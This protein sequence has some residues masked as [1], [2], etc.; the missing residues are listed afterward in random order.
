MFAA[1]RGFNMNTPLAEGAGEGIT[2]PTELPVRVLVNALHARSGGGIT[3]LRNMLPHLAADQA[4]DLHLC[5]H[6]GQCDTLEPF[7][8]GVTI[9]SVDFKDGFFRRLV[10]E[11]LRLPA[12]ARRIGAS[13]TF[14]PANFGPLMAPGSVILLRNALAVRAAETRF[15]KR[16]YWFGLAVMTTASLFSCRRA[17]AVSDYASSALTRGLARGARSRTTVVPHGVGAPFWPRDNAPHE[18]FLLAVSDLYIQKNLHRLLL[19]VNLLRQE[20]PDILLK[21][22]GAPVDLDYA[23]QISGTIKALNLGEH[24]EL[25]GSV[26]VE[27]LA[28]LY[29]RCGV[30]VFPSTAETFGNPL[31]EAMACGAPIV[32]SNTTAMPEILADA[33]L[34]F[35]PE[36]VH[37]M[38]AQIGT[39]LRDAEL[40]RQLSAR[41]LARAPRYSW[42]ETARLTA[43]VLKDC[44]NPA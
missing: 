18:G 42:E 14:S 9:H 1:D 12:L 36:D 41:S 19:A 30:F 16:L 35:D 11:Q 40:R 3:Y 37:A 8:S 27:E 34:Y 21:I 20:F 32:S 39:V 25:L 6:Q 33:A 24:V 13:V 4:I 23:Q 2:V 38:A 29:R 10:W 22:A 17:I 31:V 15:S 26:P 7:P 5:L 28:E 44:A 43:A